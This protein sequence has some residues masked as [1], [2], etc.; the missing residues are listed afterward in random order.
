MHKAA[1]LMSLFT[2]I[3]VVAIEWALVFMKIEKC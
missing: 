3:W 1:Q 2:I